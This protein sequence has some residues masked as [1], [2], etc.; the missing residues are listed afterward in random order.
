ML[1]VWEGCRC[2]LGSSCRRHAEVS[3][4][5][6]GPPAPFGRYGQSSAAAAGSASTVHQQA[7]K[8]V[9]VAAPAGRQELDLGGG[10]SKL[11]LLHLQA[12]L[13]LRQALLTPLT[14]E[15]LKAKINKQDS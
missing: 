4:V 9:R 11:L 1:G 7:R 14:L 2:H 10:V 3:Q 12:T 6:K 5:W 8:A 15:C 13:L